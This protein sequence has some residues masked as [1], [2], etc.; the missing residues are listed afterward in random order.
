MED[1]KPESRI[2]FMLNQELISLFV[3]PSC[4]DY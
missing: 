2:S 1:S 4:V 3:L